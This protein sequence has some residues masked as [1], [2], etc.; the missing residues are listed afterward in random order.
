MGALLYDMTLSPR[1]T[2]WFDLY[3]A[4]TIGR[5]RFNIPTNSVFAEGFF[6]AR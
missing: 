6:D 2:I 1:W 4:S 5:P 3:G